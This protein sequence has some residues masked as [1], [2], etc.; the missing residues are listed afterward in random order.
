MKE[1]FEL[2]NSLASTL[3]GLDLLTAKLAQIQ[4]TLTQINT[5]S[6]YIESGTITCGN[7][8][9]WAMSETL[10]YAGYDTSGYYTLVYQPFKQRYVNPPKVF[11]SVVG[12]DH[13]NQT[14]T[15]YRVVLSGVGHGGFNIKCETWREM[16]DTHTPQ[17]YDLRVTWIG[18][19]H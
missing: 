11:L 9:N 4:S 2:D 15:R 3:T 19:G 16:T 13:D 1:T 17:V 14:P 12:A 5:S 7:S 8:K 6:S 18:S 10:R